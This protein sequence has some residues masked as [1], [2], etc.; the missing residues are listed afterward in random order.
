M[1][2]NEIIFFLVIIQICHMLVA[3]QLLVPS[4]H[5]IELENL[6]VSYCNKSLNY[7]GYN[8]G[9]KHRNW[10]ILRKYLTVPPRVWLTSVFAPP[11]L[12][13]RSCPELRPPRKREKALTRASRYVLCWSRGLVLLPHLQDFGGLM[14]PEYESSLLMNLVSSHESLRWHWQT[15]RRTRMMRKNVSTKSQL[16]LTC[17]ET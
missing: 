8:Q 5:W 11:G 3:L 9:S 1:Y 12:T 2:W 13:P 10:Q 17:P 6:L 7:G 14:T 15:P 16:S 4:I